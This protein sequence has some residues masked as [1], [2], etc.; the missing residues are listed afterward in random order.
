LPLDGALNCYTLICSQRLKVQCNVLCHENIVRDF[1]RNKALVALFAGSICGLWMSAARAEAVDPQT[2]LSQRSTEISA[3]QKR[4]RRKTPPPPV[5]PAAP[6]HHR[7]A[8]P[9]FGPDGKPY[10]VP[11]YL[12]GQCYID[13]GY[14]RFTACGFLR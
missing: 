8:D 9:S 5:A 4:V 1:M 7:F 12:R 6:H 3:A 13:D 2:V 10:K 14:G 11:E